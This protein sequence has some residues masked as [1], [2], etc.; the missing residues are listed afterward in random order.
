MIMVGAKMERGKVRVGARLSSDCRCT[1]MRHRRLRSME[2][3]S[4]HAIGVQL[5][6]S[7]HG[8]YASPVVTRVF[9]SSS[10]EVCPTV[11]Q[12]VQGAQLPLACM[13]EFPSI[14]HR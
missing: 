10:V 8:R 2:D 12:R 13:V 6:P 14:S 4:W 5:R 9:H 3:V 1:T 11:H 7:R